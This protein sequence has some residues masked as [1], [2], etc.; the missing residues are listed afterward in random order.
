MNENNN[1]LNNETLIKN[2][3]K[4]NGLFILLQVI[5]SFKEN[6]KNFKQI[7][8][9]SISETGKL[10]AYFDE[11]KHE[12]ETKIKFSSSNSNFKLSQPKQSQ[13]KHSNNYL[14]PTQSGNVSINNNNGVSLILS[15]NSFEK[16][17]SLS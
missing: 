2:I 6:F 7:I 3:S 5:K 1:I 16:D 11:A 13:S 17:K 4:D 15:Q 14:I 10:K 12:I 9:K 8:M